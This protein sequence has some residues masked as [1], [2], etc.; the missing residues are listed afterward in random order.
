MLQGPMWMGGLCS[1]GVIEVS[2]SRGFW[3][4]DSQFRM[5]GASDEVY[6]RRQIDPMFVILAVYGLL[7]RRRVRVANSPRKVAA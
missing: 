4:P 6:Y 2:K 5:P 3:C 7:S 1:E